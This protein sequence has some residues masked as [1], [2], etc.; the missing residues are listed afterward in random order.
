[1]SGNC[2][3]EYPH[4]ISFTASW[5]THIEGWRRRGE[6]FPNS[7]LPLLPHSFVLLTSPIS[8]SSL[9]A[10][11]ALPTTSSSTSTKAFSK[12]GMTNNSV[13]RRPM[14]PQI[15]L[16]IYRQKSRRK[17][18]HE[19]SFKNVNKIGRM[20]CWT[21]FGPKKAQS[22][23]RLPRSERLGR[24]DMLEFEASADEVGSPIASCRNQVEIVSCNFASSTS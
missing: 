10:N 6:Y 15:P 4:E 11:T 21:I 13:S 1:M 22:G 7:P 5:R 2:S 8:I 3:S 18:G 19:S 24:E 9:R 16:G 20:R 17:A 12:Q 23:G 14:K